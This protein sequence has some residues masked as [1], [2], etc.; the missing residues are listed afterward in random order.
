M[1]NKIEKYI[2]R[3][4]NKA[5]H[6]N[7]GMIAHNLQKEISHCIFSH[8]GIARL[9]EII[10]EIEK[11]NPAEKYVSLAELFMVVQRNDL[12][13]ELNTIEYNYFQ[14]LQPLSKFINKIKNE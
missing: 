2:L 6:D 14:H 9:K 10:E 12:R 11:N 8:I 1:K 3:L 5:L 4:F 7:K 13:K